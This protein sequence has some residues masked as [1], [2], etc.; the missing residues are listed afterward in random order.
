M[1][2]KIASQYVP[3]DDL[4][5]ADFALLGPLRASDEFA[6]IRDRLADDVLDSW[7][8]DEL[9]FY[10]F[11]LRSTEVE[12]AGEPPVA[13]FVM[14]P[15][16]A[17]PL[18]AVVV[19]PRPDGAEAEV[20]DLRAPDATYVAPAWTA[21]VAQATAPLPVTT[22]FPAGE[23]PTSATQTATLAASTGLDGHEKNRQSIWERLRHWFAG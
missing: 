13:V 5:C 19:T 22:P 10:V 15:A 18:S 21:A 2:N 20:R 4:P 14:H 11:P 6:S 16:E 7:Q 9:H 1:H 8:E 3:D 12:A 17:T 23:H